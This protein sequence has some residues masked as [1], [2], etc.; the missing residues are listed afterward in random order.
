MLNIKSVRMY[1]KRVYRLVINKRVGLRV[2]DSGVEVEI[3]SIIAA[4]C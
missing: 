4:Q 3:Q 1:V 2:V